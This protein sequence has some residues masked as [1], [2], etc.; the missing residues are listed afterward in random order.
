MCTRHVCMHV[1]VSEK[2]R[3]WGRGIKE[4]ENRM[5]DSN[6]PKM[7]KGK[8]LRLGTP[9]N[10]RMLCDQGPFAIPLLQAR[11]EQNH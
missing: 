8:G 7:K 3:N 11:T 4:D 6:L 2:L 1:R 9:I 5:G 10:Q